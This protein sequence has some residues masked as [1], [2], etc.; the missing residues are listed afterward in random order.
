M[1]IGKAMKFIDQGQVDKELR[2][3]L[4]AVSSVPELFDVLAKRDLSFTAFDFEEAFNNRLVNCQFAEQAEQLQEFKQW[5]EMLHRFL[6]VEYGA[7]KG[8]CASSSQCAV[9][10]AC[11]TCGGH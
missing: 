4:N 2:K 11:K 7:P 3:A 1:T 8:D 5:W 6:G 9:A 10:G